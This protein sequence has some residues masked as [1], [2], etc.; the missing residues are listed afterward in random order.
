M[1]GSRVPIRRGKARFIGL[2]KAIKITKLELE[3]D[4]WVLHGKGSV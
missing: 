3:I 4:F 2:L 1:K